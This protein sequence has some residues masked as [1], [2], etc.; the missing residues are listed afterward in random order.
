MLIN[1]KTDGMYRKIIFILTIITLFCVTNIYGQ[2][3]KDSTASVQGKVIYALKGAKSSAALF[4]ANIILVNDI[5][6]K[7]DTLMGTSDIN[8][9]FRFINIKPKMSTIK[10][11][12]VGFKTTEGQYNL[13]QGLNQCYFYLEQ[14]NEKL[15]PAKVTAEV[16]LLKHIGDTTIYNAAAVQ[17]M[18]D[19]TL[20]DLLNR[21]PG[22][23]I[24]G[25]KIMV[26][27]KEVKRTYVN[28]TLMFGNNTT[29]A[30]NTLYA[31]EVSRV[32][33]YDEQT[34]DD[35]LRG[36]NNA[37]KQRVL[38]IKTKDS[39]FS[40]SDAVISASGGADDTGQ[41]R[42]SGI[43]AAAFYSELMS[44]NVAGTLDNTSQ[45]L[46][47]S[48][49]LSPSA[50]LYRI[51]S[52]TGQLSSYTEDASA[53]ASFEKYW[54]SRDFG[55]NI[56]VRYHYAHAYERNNL[57]QRENHYLEDGSEG[58]KAI[59][60]TKTGSSSGQHDVRLEFNLCK[61][62]RRKVFGQFN[63]IFTDASSHSYNFENVQSGE[64]LLIRNEYD[65]ANQNTY[66]LSGTLNYQDFSL[67]KVK[68][69]SI[70]SI[71]ND[72]TSTPSSRIDTLSSSTVRMNLIS[73]GTGKTSG[74]NL[75]TSAEW[76]PLNNTSKTLSFEGNFQFLWEREAKNQESADIISGTPVNYLSETYDYTF[77]LMQP[78]FCITSQYSTQ[79]IDLKAGIE[80]IWST[81][82]CTERGPSSG[83]VKKCFPA[84]L[85]SFYLKWK[86]LQAVISAK[87][88]LPSASQLRKRISNTNPLSL[89]GG[90]PN[91]KP[92]Y[93]AEMHIDWGKSFGLFS[94]STS[95]QQNLSWN[96]ILSKVLYFTEDTELT[97]WDGYKAVAGSMLYTY[98][99][100]D[101]PTSASGLTV[102]LSRLMARR[103]LNARL[104][105]NGGL[106]KSPIYFGSEYVNLEEKRLS[107]SLS[108]SWTPNKHW[109]ASLSPGATWLNSSGGA[110][111]LLSNSITYNLSSSL[112][113]KYGAFV[114]NVSY[115]FLLHD[116]LSGYGINTSRHILNA[117]IGRTF[118]KKR[119][120]IKVEAFDILNAGSVYSISI[121]PESMT[122]TWKQTYGRRFMLTATYHF[123]KGRKR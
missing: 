3:P 113:A 122:Q 48:Q 97:D 22:F 26:D 12:H 40:F 91:I 118:L 66:N 31:S 69:I 27:G 57:I 59:D 89:T 58:R 8:G 81:V 99:N 61:D 77:D 73:D 82:T 111:T 80:S 21:L 18:D 84:V 63:G 5:E 112:K 38:D 25:D 36:L 30:P 87:Q 86:G 115:N 9:V 72:R 68:F 95:F 29:T 45:N 123:R 33:V 4:G 14:A 32:K 15:G 51:T 108:L 117:N 41:A 11:S 78:S 74:A 50:M 17:M 6:G 13:A 109:R 119:L 47:L 7:K 42:Y 39:L 28:G 55:N 110:G 46:D 62:P 121:T 60:T 71:H 79:D 54:K 88:T 16:P 56:K 52:Q 107:S 64:N 53:G 44:F 23:N 105:L 1:W 65:K 49:D 35:K 20:R 93:D 103:T 10:V 114:G 90:N 100:A 67:P 85:P 92:S 101:R 76:V 34:P 37:P 24:S 70:A 43:A 75:S 106:T 96:P 120:E 104:V 19:E 102:R 83:I 98:E 2:T 116:Y 94:L